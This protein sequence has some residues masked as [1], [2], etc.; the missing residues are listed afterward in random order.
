MSFGEALA[1]SAFPVTLEITPPRQPNA[2]VLLRRARLLDG[3]A[4]AVNV[5]QRPERQ[6]SLDAALAL[7]RAGIEPVWH[8]ATGGRTRESV[9]ADAERAGAGGVAHAL[10]LRGDHRAAGGPSV[11]EAIALLRERAPGM[12]VG[13]ALDQYR[14]GEGAR[15]ALAGKLRAGASCLWTQPAFDLAPLLRAAQTAKALKP[16][17]RVMAMA[18]PMLTPQALDAIG[19]RLRIPAPEGLRRRIAAGEAEAWRAFDETLAALAAADAI[20]GVAIMTWRADPPAG[21]GERIVEGL[22]RAGLTMG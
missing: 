7:R 1:R 6:P 11:R 10:C 15:R 21:T 2:A 18:I 5:I 19:E 13:A 9:A 12:T 8:V 16:E 4:L 20:D 3:R 14:Q 17:A 22:R